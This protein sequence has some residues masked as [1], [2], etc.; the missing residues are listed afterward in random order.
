MKST[1]TLHFSCSQLDLKSATQLLAE[2][3]STSMQHDEP[4]N[5]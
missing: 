1:V 5:I 2:F 4:R 3:S